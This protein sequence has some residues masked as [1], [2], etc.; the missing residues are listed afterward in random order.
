MFENVRSINR[1]REILAVFFE[2]GFGFIISKL[3]LSRFIP[4]SKRVRLA[5]KRSEEDFPVRL[6]QSLE[7]LG[8]V[9][10]KFGQFLSLRPDIIPESYLKELEK[11]QDSAPKVQFSEIKDIIGQELGS[12]DKLFISIENKPI[13]SASV[14]QVHK[15]K[16]KNSKIVAVK[17]QKPDIKKQ[18]ERDISLIIFIAMLLEKHFSVFKR[19]NSVSIVNEFKRWSKDELDFR[20]EASNAKIFRQNFSRSKDVM[21]PEIFYSSEKV[22]VMEYIDGVELSDMQAV[23][24]VD[25]NYRRF[26]DSSYDAILTMVFEHGFFHA[27]P[28][29]AN[30]LV[31][32]GSGKIAFLDF[33]IVGSF[34]EKLKLK[35]LQMFDYILDGDIESLIKTLMSISS[36]DPDYIDKTEFKRDLKVIINELRYSSLKDINISSVFNH[37]LDISLKH[38]ISLPLDFVLFAKTVATLEGLGLRYNPDFR[39][40]EQSRPMIKKLIKRSVSPKKVLSDIKSKAMEYKELIDTLPEAAME[41]MQK[42]KKGSIRIDIE[43]TDIKRFIAEMEKSSGNLTVGFIAASLIVSSALILQ[44]QDQPLFLGMPFIPSLGFIIAAFLSFWILHRTIF[45]KFVKSIK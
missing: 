13:A 45:S 22:I 29:P 31:V 42:L 14:S 5:L 40:A 32:K 12:I 36:A 19:Y 25:K 44:I 11:L 10:I 8:P 38:R 34:D 26:L 35:S 43:D 1:L 23:K 7:Q 24:R 4:L 17:V 33:G 16:L 9:F 6:R 28:H 41:I 21:I 39:L 15:A 27:D 37:A 2:N 20:I 3:G 30:I 18:F